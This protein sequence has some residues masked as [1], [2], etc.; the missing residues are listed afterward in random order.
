MS[1]VLA[2]PHVWPLTVNPYRIIIFSISS[3]N[4]ELFSGT[5]HAVLHLQNN[6]SH[7]EVLNGIYNEPNITL[8][9]LNCIPFAQSG[10]PKEHR[11]QFT[12]SATVESI[13][14][15]WLVMSINL[16]I[17]PTWPPPFNPKL[18]YVTFQPSCIISNYSTRSQKC[19]KKT[20]N[21]ILPY[22]NMFYNVPF[23]TD[24]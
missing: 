4:S 9:S 15:W 2:Y 18:I 19:K 21:P 14:L 22:N 20:S 24:L 8:I 17:P 12:Y 16:L 23:Y 5:I 6:N 3:N 1:T 10:D 13:N 11:L 7:I